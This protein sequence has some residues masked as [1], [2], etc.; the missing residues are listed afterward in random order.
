MNSNKAYDILDLIA[1]ENTVN[2][3][4]TYILTRLSHHV[5]PEIRAY[6]AELLVSANGAEA[7]SAL[8]S[9]TG[10]N[11]EAVR[12]NAC[13]S[14][15][16]FPSINTY[17]K[18]CECAVNDSSPLVRKFALL[19]LADIMNNI[20]ADKSKLRDLFLKSSQNSDAAISSAGYRGLYMLG[21][22]KYLNN[23]IELTKAENYQDRC[24]VV[25]I[26]GDIISD[27]NEHLIISA[28]K[29]LRE[30]EQ[31]KAVNSAVDKII[32]A[33]MIIL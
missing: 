15:S 26:L 31:S 33:E 30:K 19:S 6:A 29:G 11:D 2:Q 23:L 14:L 32:D 27:E 16:A 24:S 8:I 5:D 13:D 7:E 9:L 17:E 10:D 1:R 25:N 22:K 21:D 4:D 18:L 3:S 28:L 12:V 20:N